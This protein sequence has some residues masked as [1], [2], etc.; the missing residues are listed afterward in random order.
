MSCFAHIVVPCRLCM[1]SVGKLF[2]VNLKRVRIA[3]NSFRLLHGLSKRISACEQQILCNVTTFDAL[4][5]KMCFSFMSRCFDSCN[6]LIIF[7]MTLIVFKNLRIL[8]ISQ[9]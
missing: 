5:R 2:D 9:N 1:S 6:I 3:C 7:L 8:S 4:L